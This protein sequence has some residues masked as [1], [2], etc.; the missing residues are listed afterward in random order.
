[1]FFI[2]VTG[3][4]QEVKDENM[5]I[6]CNGASAG[7]Y[8]CF[9]SCGLFSKTFMSSDNFNQNSI[10]RIKMGYVIPAMRF[11]LSSG[12]LN[13]SYETILIRPTTGNIDSN[14]IKNKNLF[15]DLIKEQIYFIN[16]RF[17]VIKTKFYD[18]VSVVISNCVP[19]N[20]KTQRN[21]ALKIL[22]MQ[23]K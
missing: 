13:E 1:L 23:F 15:K 21:E 18:F 19:L 14:P 2:G 22:K 12:N 9:I 8:N 16:V 7:Y 10:K 17:Y 6:C 4:I 3:W 5:H 11:I 20:S